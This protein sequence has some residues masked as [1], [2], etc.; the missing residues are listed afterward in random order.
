MGFRWPTMPGSGG[1]QVAQA[2][3][4][5]GAGVGALGEAI[6]TVRSENDYAVFQGRSRLIDNQ[7]AVD[8]ENELDSKKYPAMAQKAD[9]A[10]RKLLNGM[11]PMSQR[12]ASNNLEI[13]EAFTNRLMLQSQLNRER[14]TQADIKIA[15]RRAFL[16]EVSNKAR[17]L[18]VSE[19]GSPEKARAYIRGLDGLES[20]ERGELERRVNSEIASLK[21]VHVAQ[22][23]S[24]M[25]KFIARDFENIDAFI[26]QQKTLTP[27]E[28]F[29]WIGRADNY[30]KQVVSGIDITTDPRAEYLLE[31]QALNIS[32]GAANKEDVMNAIMEARYGDKPTIDDATFDSLSTTANTQ[33]KTYQ[34]NAMKEAIDYGQTQLLSKGQIETIAA[35]Q[36][37]DDE[38]FNTVLKRLGDQR[39]LEEENLS[40][41]NRA[42]TQWFEAEVKADRDPNDDDIYKE[43]RKKMVHYRG[44]LSDRVVG[45]GEL[46]HLFRSEPASKGEFQVDVPKPLTIEDV[47]KLKPGTIFMDP[48]GVLRTR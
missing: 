30:A 39:R 15:D 10:K 14:K 1:T 24:I 22:E 17:S 34:A 36:V 21:Q 19:L 11:T 46:A 2:I 33:H 41:Y 5:I 18:A 32:T 20:A 27:D 6:E 12:E 25:D 44:R 28:K 45:Q 43:S 16:D 48:K 40:E 42:M 35:L 7:L 31:T 23:Q 29:A 37:T 38:D 9:N 26:N 47:R 3:G 8:L 13:Q 4:G